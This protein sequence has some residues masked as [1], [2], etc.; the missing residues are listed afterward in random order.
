MISQNILRLSRPGS[1]RIAGVVGVL[2]GLLMSVSATEVFAADWSFDPKVAV[3]AEYDDNNRL[4]DTPG[5]EIKVSGAMLDA[6]LT[7]NAQ[8]PQTTFRLTPRL[9]STFYPGDEQEEAND[10]F[11]R[12]ALRHNGERTDAVLNADYSRV[13]TRGSYFPSSQTDDGGGLGDPDAGADV[14]RGDLRNR[15]DR[16]RISPRIAFDV[17]ERQTLTLRAA[18]LDVGYAREVPGDRVG[19]SNVSA[20]AAYRV[21]TSQ[22]ASV[23]LV[24][25]ANRY[26]PG[27]GD[28]GNSY[29]LEAEWAKRWSETAEVYVRGGA[30]FVEANQPGDSGYNSG[31][32][33][34]AGVRWAFQVTDLFLDANRYLDPNSSGE[35]VTRTQMR[36]ELARRLGPMTTLILGARVIDDSGAPGDDGYRGKIYTTTEAGFRWRMTQHFSLFGLYRYRWKEQDDAVNDAASNAVSFGVTWEPN[37]N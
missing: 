17:T 2:M 25:G 33:G 19:Y 20:S 24:A 18:Y 29:D 12:M 36:F 26:E 23:A 14:G 31:F 4:T 22:T 37:R 35:I 34:G 1:T 7:M 32:S 11:L 8:T 5:N 3:S 9:R 13:V 21:E 6:Q 16:F 27:D 15:E 28:S 10:Q 30:N